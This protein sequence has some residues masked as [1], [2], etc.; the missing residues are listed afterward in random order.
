MSEEYGSDYIVITD[1]EGN[2]YELEH[3]STIE[4]GE[5]SYMAFL[6]A[7]SDEDGEE[8]SEMIILK[9]V[10]EDG[11]ELLEAIE[12]DDELEQVYEFFM[13]QLFGDEEE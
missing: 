8:P 9:V 10:E 5:D 12:D 1:E 13:E 11:E 6:P 2:E 7:D 4:V 3:L